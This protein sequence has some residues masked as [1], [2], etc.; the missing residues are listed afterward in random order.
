MLTSL[1][2]F[3]FDWTNYSF[4]R[5]AFLAILLITPVFGLLGSIIVNNKMAFFSDALGHSALT[6]AGIGAVLGL[7]RVD[8]SMIVF[9][10]VFAVGIVFIKYRGKSAMDTT[11][12]VF[13]SIAVALGLVLLSGEG[14]NKYSSLI[15][16][17]ILSITRSELV[18]LAI[19]LPCA[20]AVWFFMKKSLLLVSMSPS[21]AISR[22]VNV[23][24]VEMIFT[25]LIAFVVTVSIKWVGILIINS[26]FVLPAGAARLAAK[27]MRSY[28]VCCVVIS[29]L[30]G[31]LGLF[32]AFWLGT[33]AG[34]TISL[35]CGA[36]YFVIFAFKR[37][38]SQ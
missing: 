29:V 18:M 8:V 32:A 6:G 20:T 15:V 23:M 34:A 31:I 9:S 36:V 24:A 5:N 1:Y 26:L 35:L 7:A 16:G 11:I 17:D 4:M 25:V 2:N 27:N 3:F 38:V 37:E 28:I 19:L 12:G 13:S 22:G 33:P 21:I 14:Y 30:C 10:A